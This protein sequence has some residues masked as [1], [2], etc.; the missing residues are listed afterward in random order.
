ML[1]NLP[2]DRSKNRLAMVRS[3]GSEAW[4][5]E[6]ARHLTQDVFVRVSRTTV[7]DGAAGEVRGWLF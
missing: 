3:V 6:V 4:D 1:S 5:A 2:P 7:P